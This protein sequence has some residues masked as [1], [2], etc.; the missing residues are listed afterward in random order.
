MAVNPTPAWTYPDPVTSKV[1]RQ[2]QRHRTYRSLACS[3]SRLPRLSLKLRAVS[4]GQSLTRSV[5]HSSSARHHYDRPP[6]SI[7]ALRWHVYKVLTHHPCQVKR[8]RHV[9]IQR[10]LVQIQRQRGAARVYD[11][12][13]AIVI[14]E[15][16]LCTPAGTHFAYCRYPRSIYH[17]AQP[18]PRLLR[19]RHA[20][21]HR[22]PH[23][24][25]V[26]DVRL[27]ESCPVLRKASRRWGKVEN[28]NVGSMHNEVAHSRQ[29]EARGSAN[30]KC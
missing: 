1:P 5:T 22:T 19:P 17:P 20:P 14:G 29:T 4:H 28:R 16:L 11:L 8:P 10:V 21:L 24:L 7:I 3:V 15:P 27:E 25:G 26:C 30:I 2:R 6:L 18:R 12:Y 9:H 23:I 13:R